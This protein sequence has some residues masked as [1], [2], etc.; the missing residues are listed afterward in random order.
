MAVPATFVVIKVFS[1][2]AVEFELPFQSF[3]PFPKAIINE[4]FDCRS[5]GHLSDYAVPKND[6]QGI[7]LAIKVGG[8]RSPTG[9]I[10]QKNFGLDRRADS[11]NLLL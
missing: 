10:I 1:V 11:G 6:H 2:F 8:H 3:R 9:Q 5:N 7:G 4:L